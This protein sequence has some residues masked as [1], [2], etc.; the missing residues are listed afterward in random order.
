MLFLRTVVLNNLKTLASYSSSHLSH[1]ELILN[2]LVHKTEERLPGFHIICICSRIWSTFR[3]LFGATDCLVRTV[4]KHLKYFHFMSL[5]IRFFVWFLRNMDC[6]LDLSVLSFLYLWRV[7]LGTSL[8]IIQVTYCCFWCN[9]L[10]L[11]SALSR[12][13]VSKTIPIMPPN[14]SQNCK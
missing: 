3:D 10:N 1:L 5:N 9:P 14:T 8:H 6:Y 11:Y 7:I 13:S 12:Q 4:Y 2:L